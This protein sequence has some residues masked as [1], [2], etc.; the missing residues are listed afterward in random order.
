MQP[1]VMRGTTASSRTASE[2]K[3]KLNIP[4][5][6]VRARGVVPAGT[7][8]Y[9]RRGPV[10]TRSSLVT[11]SSLVLTKPP[12]LSS[13]LDQQ[14]TSGACS[15]SLVNKQED[16]LGILLHPLRG[17]QEM[18]LLRQSQQLSS[19]LVHRPTTA[20]GRISFFRERIAGSSEYPVTQCFGGISS[21]SGDRAQFVRRNFSEVNNTVSLFHNSMFLKNNS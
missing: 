5:V 17:S 1:T 18:L 19:A 13:G 3:R 9:I 10:G 21:T 7:T 15:K 11:P 8:D 2:N 12:Q 4:M 14:G 16:I 6:G 20:P